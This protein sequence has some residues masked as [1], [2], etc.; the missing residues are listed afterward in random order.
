MRYEFQ[1][2]FFDGVSSSP[3][4]CTVLVKPDALLVTYGEGNLLAGDF[5]IDGDLLKTSELSSH[6]KGEVYTLRLGRVGVRSIEVRDGEFRSALNTIPAPLLPR[7]AREKSP[8][9]GLVL[10][11]L[12]G[13]LGLL[14]LTWFV[15]IP[16]LGDA[17]GRSMPPELE[18]TLSGSLVES[19]AARYNI[20]DEKT[21]VLYR[22]AA[23]IGIPD[24]EKLDFFVCESSTANAFAV[25]GGSIFVLKPM[26]S[27]LE[28]SEEMAA[29]LFHEYAHL[30]NRHTAR[31]TMRSLASYLFISLILNDSSGL[32]AVVLQNL[33]TLQRLDYSRDFEREADADAIRMLHERGLD[34]EGFAKLMNRLAELSEDRLEIPEILST[35][36]EEQARINS[37]AALAES[38]K[39]DASAESIPLGDHQMLW[40]ELKGE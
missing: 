34:T 24:V 28:S 11:L 5:L 39:A 23:A 37:A 31:A 35:H 17:V 13:M 29:L 9:N 12:A 25:I 30:K 26:I 21:A 7:G 33:D 15:I 27:E 2:L 40:Q 1:A 32:V 16:E 3:R 10:G 20:D 22:Y 38:L 4:P 18:E 19:L 8:G 36:P 6:G 14:L